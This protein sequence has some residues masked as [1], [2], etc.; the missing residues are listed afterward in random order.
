MRFVEHEIIA[1]TKETELTFSLRVSPKNGRKIKKFTAGQF[2][3][4][5]NPT[6]EKKEETRQFSI[7]SSPK[8]RSHISF[9]IKIY[10]DWTKNLS[11]K[12]IGE[13]IKLFGP[14]GIFT[15]PK[16]MK[17]AVFLAGGV[18]IAP[19]LSMLKDLARRKKIIPVTLIFA[20][21]SPKDIVKEKEITDIFKNKKNW[22]Y[23]FV[24]SEAEKEQKK[25]YKGRI[26]QKFLQE[27]LDFKKQTTYFICG[28][29]RFLTN[30]TEILTLC[31][32]SE[33]KIQKEVFLPARV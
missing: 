11:Q 23:M 20:N 17:R 24:V 12:A 13:S 19:I 14:L 6:H 16:T 3:H 5:Q 28:S 4:I 18:G 10:G 30:I 21:H 25:Y 29:Q 8:E 7:T 33:K 2:Y 1:I 22:K 32:V 31:G 15:P 27:K 9:L 26:T